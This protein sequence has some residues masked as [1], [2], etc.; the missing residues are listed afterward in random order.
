MIIAAARTAAMMLMA[1]SWRVE[2]AV[3]TTRAVHGR[4]LLSVPD[5]GGVSR[6]RVGGR[7][8]E[9]GGHDRLAGPVVGDL[10]DQA[11]GRR[12]VVRGG[13][14]LDWS[15]SPSRRRRRSQSR[16]SASDAPLPASPRLSGVEHVDRR[17]GGLGGRVADRLLDGEDRPVLDQ[18]RQQHDE[19]DEDDGELDDDGAVLAI[20]H[21]LGRSMSSPP[22]CRSRTTS[23]KEANASR[24]RGPGHD[25]G[26]ADRRG[27]EARTRRR[28]LPSWSGPRGQTHSFDLIPVS[29]ARTAAD[30]GAG[31]PTHREM[32]A[33]AGCRRC[34][35]TAGPMMTMNRAGRMKTINGKRIFTGSLAAASRTL[36]AT[37]ASHLLGLGLQHPGHGHAERVGLQQG[38]DEPVEVGDV[39]AGP[40]VLQRLTDGTG[41]AP[42]PRACG[43]ARRPAGTGTVR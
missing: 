39:R 41:R 21:G 25:E 16:W 18:A 10:D 19:E 36:A 12:R 20:P 30:H 14:C 8:G 5:D 7:E 28:W 2:S 37:P 3:A 22:S 33:T 29:T 4:P 9:H 24:N 17:P 31:C 43:R 38:E 13:A 23:R 34:E 26:D 11:L 27:D 6:R 42:S 40:Q 32:P 35:I 15:V 1:P